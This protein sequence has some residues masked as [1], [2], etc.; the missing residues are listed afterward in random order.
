MWEPHPGTYANLTALVVLWAMAL[1]LERRR[2]WALGLAGIFAAITFAFKQ[3]IGVFAVFSVC[4][5][6]ALHERPRLPGW[7]IGPG[8]FAVAL[9]LCLAF[10]AL[11]W[12]SMDL[13]YFAVFLIPLY[14]VC[15]LMLLDSLRRSSESIAV[16][17]VFREWLVFLGAFALV[18]GLWI[19]PL[20]RALGMRVMPWNLFVGR[21]NTAALVFPLI[22]P[23][24]VFPAIA[25]GLAATLLGFARLRPYGLRTVVLIGSFVVVALIALSVPIVTPEPF[26]DDIIDAPIID[27]LNW[28]T[29]TVGNQ[30]LYLPTLLF[31]PTLGML[32]AAALQQGAGTAVRW[33]WYV[34]SGVIF[35]FAQFPRVD[36]IH[37]L[38]AGLP[39]LVAATGLAAAAWRAAP[40]RSL[41]RFLV[42]IAIVGLPA[43]SISSTLTWR[44][45]AFIVPDAAHP[46]THDYVSLDLPRAPVMLPLHAAQSY[47]GVVDYIQARTSPGEPIFVFP[48]APMFYFL[49]DRPNPTRYNHLQP[50]VA[51]EAAQRQIIDD[52]GPTR[53]V[54]WDH[55]GVVDWGT[56]DAYKLVSDHIWYCFTPMEDFPPF[57]VMA[58]NGNCPTR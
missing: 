31:W 49:T 43:I 46:K 45:V 13:L 51:D 39:L 57:V 17:D 52:L 12:R 25:I 28:L 20:E 47:R 7:L 50:G 8:R 22:P 53:Y 21:V 56:Q 18:T 58:W 54:V 5:F 9:G 27:L 38:H 48:V 55:L 36:E 4:G 15:V 24:P 26:R 40:P 10:T 6:L 37:L 16:N 1:F 2:L 32:V 41:A 11:L 42:V 3:N 29:T 30:L 44:A 35:M 34:F 23:S 19:L 33:R 14:A